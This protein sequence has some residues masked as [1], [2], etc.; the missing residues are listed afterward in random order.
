MANCRDCGKPLRDSRFEVCLEC[1][2]S[3][4]GNYLNKGYFDDQGNL[5]PDLVTDTARIAAEKIGFNRKM[6]SAQ[7]RRF[8]GHAKNELNRLR[9][10]SGNYRAIESDIQKLRAFVAEAK[11][12]DKI[13]PAFYQFI[14]KNLVLVKDEK[15][16]AKGF[17][18]HFQAVV[19]YFY[20]LYPKS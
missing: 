20:Y 12:K 9:M 8:Y 1:S 4:P 2:S 11:G 18:E 13:S 10:L 14:E 7:L 17:M 19:A 5:W 3:L 16:F 15:S 6:G